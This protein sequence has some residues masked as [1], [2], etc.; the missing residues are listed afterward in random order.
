[1]IEF[2]D[3][4]DAKIIIFFIHFNSLPRNNF[5]LDLNEMQETF[6][7]SNF[8]PSV[9]NGMGKDNKVNLLHGVTS[10]ETKY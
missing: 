9:S 3:F 7:G 5:F 10:S 2:N 8:P 1:L 4:L 6:E